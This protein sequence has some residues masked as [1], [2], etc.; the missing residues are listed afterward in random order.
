MATYVI[1]DIHNSI[2]KLDKLLTLI[3]PS[4]QDQI[5]LLG[6]LFD[7][8]GA[9]PDPVGVYFRISGLSTNVKWIRG[10]HDQFLAE[11]IYSYYE[12]AEKKRNGVRAYRYNSFDLMKERLRLIVSIQRGNH[13]VIFESA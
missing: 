11:Y 13:E 7:R 3:S 10:N 12:T 4:M 5:F 1:G 8:G 9:D 2:K 6:D